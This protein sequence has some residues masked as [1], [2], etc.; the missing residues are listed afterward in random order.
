M[1]GIAGFFD[2]DR[3]VDP[4]LYDD[5][6][7]AMAD[8]LAH[9]GPDDRGTWSDADA[10]VALGFRRLSI[11]DLS[12]AGAQPMISADGA[13]VMIFNG[14]I[15]NHRDLR[16]ALDPH[17][18]RGHCD[19]EVLIEAFAR[20]GF[21]TTLKRV[22]G[23]F[24]VA[25]WD[26]RAR[27]LFL[28]RDR[29][30]EK[31]LHYGWIGGGLVFASELKA[32]AP[33]PAWTGALDHGAVSLFLGHGYV[34]APWTIYAGMRKL[35]PGTV[36]EVSADARDGICRA[37]WSAPER[38]AASAAAPFRGTVEDAADTLQAL[39]DDAVA[40]RMEAD[41]PLGAFLS[42]G[43]DSSTVVAAMEAARR[44]SV[45]SFCIGFP[46]DAHDES[47]YAENVARHLGADHT[48]LRVSE[49]ECQE[50]LPLVASVYDEPFADVSQ[51]P[52][53]VLCRLARKHVTVCLSGDG[54]DELFCG[55]D[56]Y[57][58]AA[59]AWRRLS[60]WPRPVREL[61][62]GA[63]RMLAGSEWRAA[64]R[65]R[66]LAERHAHA[67][68]ESLY[69]DYLTT[70]RPNDGLAPSFERGQSLFD[71]PLDPG[72]PSLEQNFM[73]RDAITYLPDDLLV[74]VDRASMAC[75]LEVRAP[76]LD[77]RIAEFAWSLPPAL[78]IVDGGKRV[79]RTALYRRVPRVLVDRP[80]QGFEPPL[81]RWLRG[82]LRDWADD[83]L[84]PARLMRH[85]IV[86]PAIVAQRWSAH[87]GGR[88]NWAR[89]VWPVLVLEA[90]LAE[91]DGTLPTSPPSTSP[92]S[93]TGRAA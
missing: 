55:Y 60:L 34:P 48:T 64:R 44:D 79:L 11:L 62:G 8:R 16:R 50:V 2:P 66:R 17:P 36:L 24:A 32:C 10:G 3:R 73:L 5:I 46:D 25:V 58:A 57:G 35:A 45:R 59:S 41:V 63:A 31:P 47:A 91:R 78:A 30:G 88:R 68:P 84:S 1:C 82:T 12:P 90:W 22:N 86:S 14:E 72:L 38:A 28:A 69:R 71:A 51:L 83:L 53:L 42:G 15:Y 33:H 93:R 70:W 81:A 6:A 7:G 13:L 37:Y 56:R 77:H 54:G 20:W 40:M 67:G 65:L 23:M 19:S 21:E 75:G 87:R 39:V 26:R 80:K 85:G 49:A 43:I 61:A 18:W 9:R 27:R 76:L 74:K 89:A 29:L 52:T 4:A 92:L